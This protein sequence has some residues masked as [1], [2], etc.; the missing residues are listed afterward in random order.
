MRKLTSLFVLWSFT[1][2]AFAQSGMSFHYLHAVP[3]GEYKSNLLH[4]PSGINFEY[5]TQPFQ[6]NRL[7]IGAALSVSMYQNENHTGNVNVS[8]FRK[9]Y[10]ET[11]EDDCLY[12]FQG[13]LRYYTAAEQSRLRPYLQAQAGGVSY[14]STLSMNED[15]EDMFEGKTSHH[16]TTWLLGSGIGLAV[17]MYDA[18]FID[19]SIAYNGSGKTSYRSSPESINGVSYKIDLKEYM[20]TSKVN[21]LA[22][23]L[24]LYMIF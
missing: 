21:H 18:L 22:L 12:T 13:I 9:A 23:K 16:G 4:Q 11:N 6:N 5:F 1:I 3:L 14:F 19:M 15:S 20:E 17:K 10:V 2:C 7:H 24:G 8:E